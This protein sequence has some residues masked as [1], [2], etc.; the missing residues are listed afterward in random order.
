MAVAQWV[1]AITN[2]MMVSAVG[3]AFLVPVWL[4]VFGRA[5]G[6]SRDVVLGGGALYAMAWGMSVP[7]LLVGLS[8]GT[9]L[10][11]AGNWMTAVKVVFGVLMLGM[12]VWFS[13]PAWP[14]VQTQWL[15]QEASQPAHRSVLPFQPVRSVA[16]LDEALRQAASDGR[17]VML[18]FYADWCTSCIEMERETF[19]DP[20]VQ[21]RLRAHAV[22]H[23]RALHDGF[24][25]GFVRVV[26]GQ[27]QFG[28]S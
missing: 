20:L 9:L 3:L 22:G 24:A 28:D 1:D 15:G 11:R 5:L 4:Y 10:P 26:Q 13:R 19:S 8:A 7:L 27:L 16:E 14:Y 21:D 17:P 18:D 12:A 6:Q 25:Q 23:A 2:R